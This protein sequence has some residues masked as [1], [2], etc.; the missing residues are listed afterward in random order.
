MT[1]A[2]AGCSSASNVLPGSNAAA[3][4]GSSPVVASQVYALSVGQD[5][6]A[7]RV[8][9]LSAIVERLRS[10][11]TGGWQ[12]FQNDGSGYAAEVTG[13]RYAVKG[14]PV[15][16][17][18][19]FM[20]GY[21]GLFGPSSGL[22]YGLAAAD[23]EGLATVRVTQAV[24]GV[25]VNDALLLAVVR[26]RDGVSEMQSIRGALV[27]T[28]GVGAAPDV[29]ADDAVAIVSKAVGAP[30]SPDPLLVIARLQGVPRLAWSVLVVSGPDDIN[31]GGA[32]AATEFPAVFYVDAAT[33]R[34]MGSQ[35]AATTPTGRMPTGVKPAT[36]GSVFAGQELG[37]YNYDVP[38][39]GVPIVIETTY[40]G[41]LPIRVN[42]EQLPDGSIAMVDATGAQ[43]DKTS[44]RGL[45]V[46]LDGRTANKEENYYG[47]LLIYPNVESIPA[48]VLYAMWGAR[49]TNDYL[50]NELGILSFDGQNSP[51][52]I[53]M[54]DTD[55]Q[56]CLDNAFFL[57]W[58]GKSRM[59]VGVPCVDPEGRQLPTMADIDTI[60]HELGHGVV[61]S[62]TTFQ[63]NSIQ[64]GAID[65]GTADY[66]GAILRN[67]AYGDASPIS[68]GDI[69][70]GLEGYSFCF[71]WKDG[72]GIRSLNTGATFDQY[73]FTLD[74]P[75]KNLRPFVDSG[76]TN[77][78]VWTNALWQARSA[79]AAVDGGDAVN[80]QRA[81]AFDR[82]V[83]RAARTY[84]VEGSDMV[85][86]GT[87][88][89][90]AA[91]DL[92]MSAEDLDLISDR[93]RANGLCQTCSSVQ[94]LTE[95]VLPVSVSVDPKSSPI[96]V[97]DRVA[98]LLTLPGSSPVAVIGTPGDPAQQQ[99]LG[100]E[101]TV[102]MSLGGFGDR[103]YQGQ[104]N[105][106]TKG[107][108]LDSVLGE[109][110]V[111]TGQ[112]EVI[113]GDVF[114]EIAPVATADAVVWVDRNNV[115]NHRSL[116]DGSV[117]Q[118]PFSVK[119]AQVAASGDRVA[120]LTDDGALFVWTLSANDVTELVRFDPS[121]LAGFYPDAFIMP[122]GG[123]AMSGERIAV[124]G[125]TRYPGPLV[126][127]DLAA[128]TMTTYSTQ[129]L[130]LGVAINDSYVVWV[131]N[132]GAQSSPV[133]GY[134]T[135]GVGFPD[136]ELRG[137]AF[138]EETYYRMVNARGQQGFPSLSDSLLAWQ[139]SANGNSDIYAVRLPTE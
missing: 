54:F 69:C 107:D 108:L 13:G 100:P 70:Q 27:D 59:S 40:L 75:Y 97:G 10:A 31:G 106:S 115:I 117:R 61:H 11:S 66:L 104:T 96:A 98:F 83:V 89:L 109:A 86:A 130:P 29:P 62:S 65:E 84:F 24:D 23:A 6:Q 45:I 12:A 126:V 78:M 36:D 50:Y 77:S 67:L 8:A 119:I 90:R 57:T 48:D 44:K 99:Y 35:R 28:Q 14:D 63:R 88:V 1:L 22:Q 101:A 73:L 34:I 124:V 80:S 71:L 5:A 129:A 53:V 118:Q 113:A 68:S 123:L 43:A 51:I 18:A 33:G 60:A 47:Q 91:A 110:V 64:Q 3:P 111:S 103:V 20:E 122:T 37:Y 120:V 32:G 17:V 128:G 55:G 95:G 116:A 76:H 114:D 21:G 2:L 133:N 4:G 131:E 139:E 134:G 41:S 25:P 16:A 132:L 74:D 56:P 102:T 49:Q 38:P 138:G 82:A 85:Q 137:F 58:P 42:A 9:E 19:S 79:L 26:Q 30:A 94:P 135:E 15:A 121:P 72:V 136:T 112:S 105:Y 87:A 39:G 7:A 92:G 46:A 127:L 93:L 81:R 52:P 125:T